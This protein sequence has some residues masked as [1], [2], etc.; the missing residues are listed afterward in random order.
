MSHT[1][2]GTIFF[3]E[4]QRLVRVSSVLIPLGILLVLLVGVVGYFFFIHGHITP[5]PPS[6]TTDWGKCI[7]L[8]VA[9]I[10]II[11]SILLILLAALTI[12]V[13]HD[14]LYVQFYPI[15]L[16]PRKILY[17][18]ITGYRVITYRPIRD[19]GGWGLKCGPKGKAYNV[20]GN[21]GVELEFSDGKKLM[22][23]SQRPE[24]LASAL[25]NVMG[26]QKRI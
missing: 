18:T 7:G 11:G 25:E 26:G 6:D 10:A 23:G 3:R 4:V 14:A 2:D 15:H 24:E 1:V 16:S 12:E 19:Y 21:R 13:K 9:S 8:I 5:D 17:E 22:L 20:S